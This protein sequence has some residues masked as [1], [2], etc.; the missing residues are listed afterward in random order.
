MA[1]YFPNPVSTSLTAGISSSDATMTVA[2]ATGF[3][4]SGTFRVRIHDEIIGVTAVSGTTWTIVRGVEGTTAAAHGPTS[5]VTGVLTA[6]AI[7]SVLG[8]KYATGTWASRPAAG[9]SGRIYVATDAPLKWLDNGVSWDLISPLYI[10]YADRIQPSQY[11]FLLNNGGSY[12][13]EDVN[14]V[15]SVTMPA[16]PA[17]ER[18]LLAF[19][20]IPYSPPYTIT[21]YMVSWSLSSDFGGGGLLLRNSSAFGIKAMLALPGSTNVIRVVKAD[22]N[23]TSNGAAYDNRAFAYA[24]RYLGMRVKNNGTNL[25]W[26]YSTDATNW[27]FYNSHGNADYFSVDQCGFI[28]ISNSS[29]TDHSG[30]YFGLNIV[31]S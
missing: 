27:V 7:A 20:S 28:K 2:S 6:G 25:L 23:G 26:Y 8:A 30:L 31:N 10:P 12:A 11:T 29:I 18:D 9:V 21:L 22:S 1:E 4:S 5:T 16:G 24:G 14:G 17:A 19:K 13:T 3:P 15:L